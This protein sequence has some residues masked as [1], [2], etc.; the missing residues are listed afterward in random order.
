MLNDIS[1]LVGML[2]F[3]LCMMIRLLEVMGG[4]GLVCVCV[5]KFSLVL[6]F[7]IVR[8]KVVIVCCI[9][10]KIVVV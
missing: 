7:M 9:Y 5:I 3:V 10:L 8:R 2:G 1:V 4:M 6:F